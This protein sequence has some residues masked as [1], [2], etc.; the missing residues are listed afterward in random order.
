MEKILRVNMTRLQISQAEVP[1]EYKFLG[2]RGLTSRMLLDE[3]DPRCE[4]LGPDNKVILAP[5]LLTGTVVPCS[6]RLSI[7]AKSPLTGAIKESN[8]GGTAAQALTRL[9]IKALVIEGMPQSDNQYLL[10]LDREGAALVPAPELADM[11]NYRLAETLL[12]KYGPDNSIIS[13]G[14]AGEQQL[15]VASVAVTNI[16]GQPSRHAGRGGMGAVL[17]SKGIKA[18]VVSSKG[19]FKKQPVRSE[20]FR[21]VAQGFGKN[22]VA[23]KKALTNYGTAVL[24]NLINNVGGLP[25]NNFSQGTF[26]GVESLSGEKLAAICQERGGATGHACHRGCVIRCSNIYHDA[27]GSYLTSGLE[28]ETIALMGSNLGIAGLDQVAAMDRI[29]DDLGLDTME[30]GAALGVAMEGGVLSFGDAGGAQ[31]LLVETAE[32]KTV[33]GR[34]LGQGA[35]VTGKVLN[36]LRVPAV[37]GQGMSAYD[38]RALKGT[39]V[40]YAT[41]TMGSDHTAGNALPG[42]GKVELRKPEGQVQLSLSLQVMSS[43]CDILGICIFVGPVEESM[44]VCA[45]LLSAFSGERWGQEEVLALGRNLL[46]TEVEFNS[47]AGIGPVYNDVPEFMRKEALPGTDLVFDVDRDE[48]ENIFR[49]L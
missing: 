1:S 25:T 15:P 38:P 37:K 11:G 47:K 46:K 24:V 29:C 8:V 5:G 35:T 40:T 42:R 2:G 39:G 48:L 12:A 19:D 31:R 28:Y 43:V 32:G 4:A 45:E 27:Q 14:P 20:A 7:G 10:R 18:V 36:V 21:E 33:L 6:G 22:L 16:E 44:V 41:S 23:S 17:G 34:V 9:G 49:G 13:I 3:V 26:A 30:M